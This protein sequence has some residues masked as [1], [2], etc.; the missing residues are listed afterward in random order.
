VPLD[1]VCTIRALM[2]MG[3]VGSDSLAESDPFMTTLSDLRFPTG[4][5]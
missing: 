1:E 2:S 3:S 4:L 5:R